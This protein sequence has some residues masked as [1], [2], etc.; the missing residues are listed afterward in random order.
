MNLKNL[1][2]YSTFVFD[3]DGVILNSNPIK[4]EAFS[5]VSSQFGDSTKDALLSYHLANGGIS[6]YH[7]LNY[8][9]TNILPYTRPD[10]PLSDIPSVD[11]LLSKYASYVEDRLLSCEC[12]SSFD[13][14]RLKFN[15]T[16]FMV[17]SGSDQVELRKVFAKRNLEQFFAHG[18]FG[19]PDSKLNILTREIQNGNLVLPALYLGD[20]N[21]DMQVSQACGLDFAFVT[22]WSDLQNINDIAEQNGIQALPNL[23]H[24][25][26]DLL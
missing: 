12:S 11:I 25:L 6:R 3:C 17:V 21:Y 26:S 14:L 7:K 19:S 5:Y 1:H 2:E 9:L 20:T 24:L 13:S 15:S 10:L 23:H 22:D 18:I 4:A 8:L 16:R